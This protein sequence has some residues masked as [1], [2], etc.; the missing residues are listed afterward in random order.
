[1]NVGPPP[2]ARALDRL[3]RRLVDREH[4]AAVDAHA[5]HPVADGL[6]GERLGARLRLERRRDRPLVVVAEE[7]QRR[8]HH[9]REVGALVEGALARRAVAE[10]RD[11]D[12][13]VA[14]QLLAPREAGRVR[15][16]R[17][18]RHADR[19]DAVLRRVPPAGRMAAPPVEDGARPASR[20]AAR[21]PTRGSSG[22]S[23]PRRRARAPSRPA[24]PRGS[25][26]SRT[27]RSGPGGGRRPSARRTCAAGSASGRSR[28]ARRRR[29]RRP[30]APRRS[31]AAARVRP[32]PPWPRRGVYAR[33]QEAPSSPSTSPSPQ[34]APRHRRPA[35]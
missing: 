32:E 17:R 22:R 18:D 33:R 30:R 5:R 9:R 14:L 16:V 10:V 27:S 6:V 8:L 7:D 4:V 3:A 13:R 1:M 2:P 15:D 25:R 20:A 28:A 23:S 26:R 12:G 21:S 11:R 19:R 34:P 35:A 31:R 24:S 29:D